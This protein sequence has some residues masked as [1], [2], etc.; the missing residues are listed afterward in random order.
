MGGFF[1]Q[2]RNFKVYLA[3]FAL[4]SASVAYF[5]VGFA[6]TWNHAFGGGDYLL[7]HGWDF[8]AKK[9]F[10][11]L[12]IHLCDS[13]SFRQLPH[14]TSLLDSPPR[15]IIHLEEGLFIEAWVGFLRKKR[16]F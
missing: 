9:Q 2:K 13:F 10:L 5:L 1:A 16:N 6:S 11:G 4:S 14:L 12:S 8:W 3:I 15:G 7:R